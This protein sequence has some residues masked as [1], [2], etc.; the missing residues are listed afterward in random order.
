MWMGIVERRAHANSHS[1]FSVCASIRMLNTLW[2]HI[3]QTLRIPFP[4]IMAF[5]HPHLQQQA[6]TAHVSLTFSPKDDYLRH[7]ISFSSGKLM[8]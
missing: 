8:E 6:H 7:V 5:L 1:E 3:L 4:V 2:Y